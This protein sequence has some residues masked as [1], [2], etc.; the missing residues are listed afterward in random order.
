MGFNLE[1]VKHAFP[2]RERLKK[3]LGRLKEVNLQEVQDKTY[4]H[5][6]LVLLV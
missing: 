5:E 4:T 1:Q 2:R 6:L 3:E